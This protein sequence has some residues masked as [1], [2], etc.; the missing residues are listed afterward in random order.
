MPGIAFFLSNFYKRKE[1]Y[2]RVGIFVSGASMAGAFGGLL[3]TGLSRIPVWGTSSTP[4]HTWRN[5]VSVGMVQRCHRRSADDTNLQF[6]F[7][8]LL[9]MI[10]GGLAPLVLPQSPETSKVLTDR[11]RFI[12]AERLRIEH[13]AS[14]NHQV[15]PRH[16]KRAMLNINNY[17]CAAGFFC[18]NSKLHYLLSTTHKH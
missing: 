14:A 12:A 16:I 18:T 13:K 1:L 8:G 3:A 17:I 15:K 5:I 2:F 7:E 11:E 9:T 6:F 4:I 10:L